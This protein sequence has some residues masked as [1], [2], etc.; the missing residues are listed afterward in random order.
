MKKQ[1]H[2]SRR[3]KEITKICE[4]QHCVIIDNYDI[5]GLV[6]EIMHAYQTLSVPAVTLIKNWFVDDIDSTAS[7]N[8]LG[9]T[10]THVLSSSASNLWKLEHVLKS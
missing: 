8:N 3:P 2:L 6:F 1:H 4:N 9:I 10:F 5:S 7:E